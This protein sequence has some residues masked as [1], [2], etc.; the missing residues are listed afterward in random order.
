MSEDISSK[1]FITGKTDITTICT[2]LIA[3]IRTVRFCAFL[4]AGL[5]GSVSLNLAFCLYT[6]NHDFY[7][8]W[9]C[10][11]YETL[12]SPLLS[13]AITLIVCVASALSSVAFLVLG[14]RC[15]KVELALTDAS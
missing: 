5:F 7:G 6:S 15:T 8:M 2:S 11:V 1:T 13:K 14:S 3:F 12:P 4:M 9:Y 10:P